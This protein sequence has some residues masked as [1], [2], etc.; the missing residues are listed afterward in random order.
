[1]ENLLL[2]SS[3]SDQ[4]IVK[5]AD[6]GWSVKQRNSRHLMTGAAG[7][8]PYMAPEML[9]GKPYGKE[10]DVWSIGVLAF[11]LLSGTL[12]FYHSK[13]ELLKYIILNGSIYFNEKA[14]SR[15]SRAGRN[16]VLK[17]LS[18]DR[19][20]RPTIEE[21]LHHP[22]FSLHEC[23][24]TSKP[25]TFG[26]TLTLHRLARK[27]KRRM[28]LRKEERDQA[29]ITADAATPPRS[30]DEVEE[31]AVLFTLPPNDPPQT[32]RFQVT[33]ECS[34]TYFTSI[35]LGVDVVT[36]EEV[37]VK[38]HDLSRLPSRSI[39]LLFNEIK[40]LNTLQQPPTTMS[41]AN[42]LKLHATYEA[43]G[44]Y[45]VVEERTSDQE[46]M[47]RIAEAISYDEQEAKRLAAGLMQAV[48]LLHSKDI[49]HR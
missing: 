39:E 3:E 34:K 6:F 11:V 42:V 1:M 8:L 46:V 9:A 5:I 44:K 20:Q 33:C 14:W 21:A 16:F 28:Q 43:G 41:A 7:S 37:V 36:G 40:T 45:Y 17:L 13:D 38:V 2:S 12:P 15:V 19:S 48:A 25:L 24:L 49:V 23:L 26:S 32:A 4:A 22:W 18:V 31:E 35:Y 30:T 47:D 27:W 29:L 10:V